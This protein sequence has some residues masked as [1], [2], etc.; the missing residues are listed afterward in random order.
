M[1]TDLQIAYG[2]SKP[3]AA[4]FAADF[5]ADMKASGFIAE[6]IKRAGLR[7]AN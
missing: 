5:I 4:K 2:E 1:T 6:A 3:T 7:G